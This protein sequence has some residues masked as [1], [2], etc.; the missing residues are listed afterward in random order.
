MFDGSLA[1]RILTPQER[2]ARELDKLLAQVGRLEEQAV[3]RAM[4]LL[5]DARRRV[6]ERLASVREGSFLAGY[7]PQL[8]REI[9]RVMADYV[10]RYRVIFTED[11][12]QAWDLGLQSVTAPLQAAGVMQLVARM[13]GLDPALPDVLQGFHARLIT[14]ISD[15]ARARITT[16]LQLGVLGGLSP[17]QMQQRIAEILRTQPNAAGVFGT[18]A[19]RAEAIQRTELNRVFSL[20]TE[21]RQ[22]QLV[23]TAAT[24]FPEWQPRKRWLNA[25]DGRVRPSHRRAELLAQ[26]PLMDG[27]EFVLVDEKGQAFKAKFPLDP[28]LPASQSVRCRCKAILDYQ[29]EGFQALL[30]REAA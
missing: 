22:Q 17:W 9:E 6:I 15:Y 8:Q 2:Y 21:A 23:T 10:E 18:V 3:R 26:R 16:E 4:G 14:E 20:A 19:N 11:T 29:D 7:L 5:A 28:R 13:P 25:G 1:E 12:I 27:G 30:A 24:V